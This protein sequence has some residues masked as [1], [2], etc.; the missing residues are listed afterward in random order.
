M[1][2]SGANIFRLNFSHGTHEDHSTFLKH[3]REEAERLDA[4]IAVFQDL[5]GPKVRIGKVEG[6][7][8]V[9]E[10]GKSVSLR[11]FHSE[12][13]NAA[14]LYVEAFDPAKV[15]DVGERAF[16]SDGQIELVARKVTK[17][18]AECEVVSGGVVRSRSGIAVPESKLDLTCITPKDLEDL[19]WGVE[20]RLDYIALSFVS[21]SRDVMNIRA[22]LTERGAN[23]PI[24][25]KVERAAALDD[26]SNIVEAA[27][28]VM[29]ARG[30]LGLELPLERV[31]LAQKLIIEQANQQGTPVITA[32][33]M[34]QSMVH[35]T[36]PTRAEVSDVCTAVLDGTDAVMLSEETAIGRHPVL[37]IKML[38][39]IIREAECEFKYQNYQPHSKGSGSASIADAICFAACGAADKI[40][41]SAILACTYT[42]HTAR[43]VAKYRPHQ[44]LFGA[45]TNRGAISRMALYWGVEPVWFALRE[46]STTEEEIAHAMAAVRDVYG[47]K[48][49][50]RVVVTAGLKTRKQGATSLIEIR[51][52]PRTS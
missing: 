44:T 22:L 24:I 27:D 29:V 21:S 19:A 36:V 7:A 45:T 39:R 10:E 33:Q 3:V 12:V 9:L 42:G 40:A 26:I 48:P 30:D 28:A 49:G 6:D 23:I 34:L 2:L 46:N 25:A 50:A 43:L 18:A 35:N 11:H 32:T 37:A 4:A 5:C 17:E 31:P 38:D 52:I 41:A 15:M 13:G 8:V 20:N 47:L 14:A 16:L 1:I 51:E